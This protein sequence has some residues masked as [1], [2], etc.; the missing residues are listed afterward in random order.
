MKQDAPSPASIR[1][2]YS[3]PAIMEKIF[4]VAKNRE[5]VPVFNGKYGK[6][7]DTVNMQGDL[8]LMI[9]NGATSF[10]MSV[11][12]WKNPLSISNEMKQ[13]DL[14]NLRA[15]WDILLDIDCDKGYVYAKE[16]AI[17]LVK[18]LRAHGVKN[19]FVKFS[20][21]RGFHIAVPF[22]SLPKEVEGESIVKMYPELL[23][24]VARYLAAFIKNKLGEVLIDKYPEL[25]NE[26]VE[27]DGTINPYRIM[28]IEENWSIR[29]L[30][31]AP[32]S[33]N[34]KT[35][36][37][38]VP[39]TFD[40]LKEFDTSSAA[41]ESV[42]GS[43]GFLDRWKENEAEDLIMEVLDWCATKERTHSKKRI[44]SSSYRTSS[45]RSHGSKVSEQFFPPCIKKGLEGLEDG[46]KRFLF[47]LINFLKLMNWSNEEIE[48]KVSEWNHN[49]NKEPLRESYVK[50]QLR[51]AFKKSEAYVTPN[52]DNKDYY[53]DIGICIPDA[54]CERI[55]NPVSYALKRMEKKERGTKR[56]SRRVRSHTSK[57]KSE[58]RKN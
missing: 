23:Q 27:K 33:L 32:Y 37:V 48:E 47:I 9:L 21:S 12:R 18:A 4:S 6:R 2:Y 38:S 13:R 34:E 29:H 1:N 26:I 10:H 28:V 17:L 50:S 15:G 3:Q 43:V 40:Q 25:V 56:L 19:V 58:Q 53:K 49:K 20:G 46:R 57:S 51:Y 36:L 8:K 31:R 42:D 55:N 39:L 22:E 7:P 16:A 52:C 30:F 24:N 41:M 14:E 5:F 45:M 44:V 11:E 35:W 54:L